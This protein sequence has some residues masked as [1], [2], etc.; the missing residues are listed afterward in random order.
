[1]K[2]NS[3]SVISL[4]MM[5]ALAPGVSAAPEP[6]K[7]NVVFI[8]SDDQGW[9]DYELIGHPHIDTPRL[10]R[11]AA[12]SI[13]FQRDYTPVP[14][15]CPSL[16]SILTGLYPHQHGV[17]GND[18]ELPDKGIKPRDARSDPKYARYLGSTHE[19]EKIVRQGANLSG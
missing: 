10:D 1:M 6:V 12:Q 4:G 18:P 5:F 15:C 3:R 14:L 17:T 8:I 7:P 2:T 16:A 13:T 19:T 9:G 11:L